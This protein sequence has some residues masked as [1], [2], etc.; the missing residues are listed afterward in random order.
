[1]KRDC[2]HNLI[3]QIAQEALEKEKLV[4]EEAK[5]LHYQEES[6]KLIKDHIIHAEN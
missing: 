5:F 6:L 2:R 1:M 4:M 3:P